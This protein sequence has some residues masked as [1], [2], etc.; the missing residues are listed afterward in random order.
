MTCLLFLSAL[1]MMYLGSGCLSSANQ[2]VFPTKLWGTLSCFC[3][4][5]CQYSLGSVF[6]VGIMCAMSPGNLLQ[7][8]LMGV[9]IS[10]SVFSFGMKR[11]FLCYDTTGLS[12]DKSLGGTWQ[13]SGM[14]LSHM[15]L[16]LSGSRRS[17]RQL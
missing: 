1:Q 11:V 17:V 15:D 3:L 16:V 2:M 13:L 9:D 12:D 5:T 4:W 6:C 10:G 8:T 14:T 7:V